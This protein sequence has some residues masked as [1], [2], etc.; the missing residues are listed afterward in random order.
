MKTLQLSISKAPTTPMSNVIT[1]N[2]LVYKAFSCLTV[3]MTA[4]SK[5]VDWKKIRELQKRSHA[6]PTWGSVF[7]SALMDKRHIWQFVMIIFSPQQ[8][9]VA[10]DKYSNMSTLNA[11]Y[12]C[13]LEQ[14]NEH[15]NVDQHTGRINEKLN[16]IE[17]KKAV[18]P[19]TPVKC[20]KQTESNF[21]KQPRLDNR[22]Q[23]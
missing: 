23:W 7:I 17:G 10:T 8:H 13:L 3:H 20:Q 11:E 6:E 18:H 9:P 16:F 22:R 21:R 12:T 19:V 15:P 5:T 14:L 1:D 4:V 2:L